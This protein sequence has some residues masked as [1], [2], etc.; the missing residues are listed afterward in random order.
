[1]ATENFS[2]S[3]WG[4]RETIK[5]ENKIYTAA[6]NGQ[7]F[8]VSNKDIANVAFH[9]LTMKEKPKGDYHV[10]GPELLTY[11]DVSIVLSTRDAKLI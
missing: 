5:N 8:W 4:Y 6:E 2:G 7:A 1:M 11:D 9:A 3:D 10:L